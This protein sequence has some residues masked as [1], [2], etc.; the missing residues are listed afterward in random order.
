MTVSTTPPATPTADDQVARVFA[1]RRGFDAVHL[2]ALGLDLGLFEALKATPDVTSAALAERLGFDGRHVDVWCRTACGFGLLDGADPGPTWRLAPHFDQILASPTHPR[3][4]GAYVRLGSEVAA[5]DFAQLRDAFRTG[6]AR[7]FQGRGDGFNALIAQSTWGL[8][9]ATTKKLLPGLDGIADRLAAGGTV[10]EV[11]CG[12]GNLLALLAKSF[13][14]ARVIG[15]DIE[16]DSIAA[17]QARIAADGLA[18]RV[19]ARAG[20][21][22]A[23]VAPASVDAIV[24]VEVLHEIAPG[25]RDGVIVECHRALRPG[26]WLLV[27][28]ETYP[29]TLD[30]MRRPE[31]Q[32]PLMT[33]FEELTWGNVIPT[34]GEQERLLGAAG[35]TPPYERSLLGE[36]FTVLAA[37]R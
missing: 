16:V 22:G 9:V 2:I 34:R 26:G 4:L 6:K 21:L 25:I 3:F 5:D 30:E 14:A 23:V 12:T 32:F 13:P 8:Q 24:M 29:E 18:P 35:F 27:V 17:A 20:T 37:R 31:F 19:E 15:V 1:W 28:D 36:G 10:V 33:G 11:G 7:P